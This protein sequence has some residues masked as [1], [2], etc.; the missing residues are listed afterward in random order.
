MQADIREI[1]VTE[2]GDI[3]IGQ[4][5]DP[6]AGTGCTV[7][8]SE[9][10]MP[11]GLDVRGGGPASRE[12]ELL[13]PLAAAQILH[14]IL[15]AGG[16]AY[17]LSAATGVMHY[18]EEKGIGFDTGV[19]KV[20]LVAQSDLFDLTVGNPNIRPDEKMGYE[21]ARI[22]MEEPNYRDGNYGAGCG[23]TVGKIAGMETC[24]KTGIG[25]YA[26]QIGELK[27]GAVVALNA[28]GDVI[29][30]K[31]GRKIA[32]LLS[33]DKK[34][35]RDTVEYMSQKTA[36]IDNR[37]LSNT[38]LGVVITNAVFDKSH[39]CKVAGM[40]HDG[41]ARS[42]RPVHT[43]ADGDSI[44]AVSVGNVSADHDLVGTWAA[45]VVSAAIERA[46]YGADSAYGYISAKE[47]K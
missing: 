6:V 7:F 1:K 35:F 47:V 24:M 39:L 32:G 25:S 11:A 12:S 46:V 5:E 43:S 14:G 41:Y 37:Y 40:A 30:W 34:S 44:Y 38:T 13:K 20:P 33:E 18:L 45:E 26:V 4:T 28:L 19:A 42:I 31:S 36:V 21:A 27:I 29:E 22:A 3:H 9:K 15:L 16:S 2:I 23:A 8:I 10:G 17:G